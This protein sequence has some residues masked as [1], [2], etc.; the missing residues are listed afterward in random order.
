MEIAVEAIVS[1]FLVAGALFALIGSWGLA[2]LPDIYMRLHAP[3]KASTLG[4]GGMLLASIVHF[5]ARHGEPSLHELAITLMLILA[6][7][8]G[9]HMVAKA[10]LHRRLHSTC[11]LPRVDDDDANRPA[12]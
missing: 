4:V 3:S 12:D 6:T 9:A 11:P 5:T 10:A 1:L 8:V 7:P 2:R